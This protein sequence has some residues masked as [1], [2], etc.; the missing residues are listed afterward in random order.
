[1][2]AQDRLAEARS[3]YKA[4]LTEAPDYAGRGFVED[5]IQSLEQKINT[6]KKP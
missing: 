6:T 3:N 2:A 1:L 5:K 4:L